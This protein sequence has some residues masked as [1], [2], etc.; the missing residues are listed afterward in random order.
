MSF[1]WRC[2]TCRQIQRLHVDNDTSPSTLIFQLRRRVVIR[3]FREHDAKLC[4][5]P[6][7]RGNGTRQPKHK[8]CAFFR[9]ESVLTFS[10]YSAP[11][12]VAL[13][14]IQERW[15]Q[16]CHQTHTTLATHPAGLVHLVPPP[17]D[18]ELEDQ[19]AQL[20]H[21]ATTMMLWKM[22]RCPSAPIDQEM[23]RAYQKSR[24]KLEYS[25]SKHLKGF[26]RLS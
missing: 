21:P 7:A 2:N 23:Q 19:P 20:H 13:E 14:R 10:S 18:Q 25:S 22:T 9:S 26:L 12:T 16:S 4:S 3:Q 24:I 11:T 15:R 6:K 1:E 5:C 17:P 8:H